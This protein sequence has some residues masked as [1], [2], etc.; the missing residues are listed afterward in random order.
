MYHCHIRFCFAGHHCRAFE[1]IKGMAPL[2]HFTHEFSE[3]EELKAV[4]GMRADVVLA[5]LQGVGEQEALRAL[6]TETAGKT[7]VILL[8]EKGETC[9][10]LEELPG[11][12]DLWTLP[13]SEEEIRFRF[14]RW[15]QACKLSKD[16]W[17]TSQ[18][19][20]ATIDHVPNLIWY[21]TKDGIHEKVNE[22]FCRTVNKTRK[23]VEGR[24]HAYI[25]DVE[26]DDP[27][28]IES[29]REVMATKQTC[30]SEET[31]MTGGGTRLLTTY[32]SPLY[33]LDG[34]VMGTVGVAIDVTQERAYEQEIV[35]RSRT[36]ETIFTTMD[37][38][39][40]SHS[41]DGSRII[42]VNEAALKILG[43]KSQKEMVD[44]GFDMVA[45][46]VVDE[47]KP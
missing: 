35:R 24:G 14:L 31:V 13:M 33:D 7:E 29:E 2:E 10:F 12:K 43:Y 19:L 47:D 39:I 16:Y 44:D 22:S 21:K 6:L 30:V 27:A 3:C 38:G 4:S 1:I 28:C 8:A 46:S 5:N 36:L 18:Y 11:L 45:A 15:Q 17:Q 26:Q 32:K 25:W 34:S 20:E 23:Q 9:L 41:M 40:M 37:C 42:S